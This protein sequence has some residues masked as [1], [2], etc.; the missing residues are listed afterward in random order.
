MNRTFAITGLLAAGMAALWV[1]FIICLPWFHIYS[2]RSP[3]AS[4][5]LPWV[6]ASAV[7]VALIFAFI[8]YSLTAHWA[9]LRRNAPMPSAAWRG[10]GGVYLL[11][12][13]AFALPVLEG[14]PSG[15][16][17]AEMYLYTCLAG[18]CLV[19]TAVAFSR[20]FC[21]LA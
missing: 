16:H 17:R 1:W 9:A 21:R 14:D 10:V 2:S 20:G 11:V 3:V 6:G 13:L 18:L 7:G 8:R 4:I 19:L 12:M 5:W 15:T